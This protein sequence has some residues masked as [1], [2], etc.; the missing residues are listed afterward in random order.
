[1]ARDFPLSG[2]VLGNGGFEAGETIGLEG[3]RW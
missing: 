1:M 3:I 2:D